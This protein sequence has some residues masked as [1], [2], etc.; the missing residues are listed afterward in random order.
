LNAGL[1]FTNLPLKRGASE[2]HGSQ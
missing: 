2:L 1:E